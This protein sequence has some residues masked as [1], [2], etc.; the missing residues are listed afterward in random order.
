MCI[1]IYFVDKKNPSVCNLNSL[2]G[3]TI[4]FSAGDWRGITQGNNI[5]NSY[6]SNY[7]INIYYSTLDIFTMLFLGNDLYCYH[8]VLVLGVGVTTLDVLGMLITFKYSISSYSTGL[9]YQFLEFFI[10]LLLLLMPQW[11]LLNQ[12]RAA[13]KISAREFYIHFYNL[14]QTTAVKISNMG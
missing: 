4:I 14:V 2:N 3:T 13:A 7:G 8:T 5:F 6:H 1:S 10:F 9:A 11:S 12:V